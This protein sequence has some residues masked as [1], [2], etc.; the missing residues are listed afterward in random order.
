MKT[1]TE[2]ERY[3]YSLTPD[4]VVMDLGAHVGTWTRLICEKYDC[5]SL[6]FEPITEFYQQAKANLERFPKVRLFQLGVGRTNHTE[7]WAKKG[8]MTGCTSTGDN[9]ETVHIRSIADVIEEF[10]IGSNI[11]RIECAKIN[12]EGGEYDV[13]EY[14]LDKQLARLFVNIQVQPHACFPDA[15]KRWSA[16]RKRMEATHRLTWDCPWI[17]SNWELL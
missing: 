3:N 6:A 16:I 9:K 17:W 8:D 5:H 14:L 11:S 2:S 15:E 13:L 7:T 1:F 10:G 4:S 12:I